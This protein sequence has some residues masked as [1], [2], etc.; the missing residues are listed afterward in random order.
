MASVRLLSFANMLLLLLI[1]IG[2]TRTRALVIRRQL[3]PPA[4]VAPAA[5]VPAA[6]QQLQTAA[7]QQTSTS[8]RSRRLKLA[9]SMPRAL[10]LIA[11]G[12]FMPTVSNGYLFCCCSL[13][14][15]QQPNR[16]H[17]ADDTEAAYSAW[18]AAGGKGVDTAFMY[19]N[20]P[21]IGRALAGATPEQRAGGRG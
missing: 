9:G 15:H 4:T 21:Q 20:Q 2:A 13:E 17:Q 3:Q 11:P 7:A 10:N 19:G 1:S 14:C 12:V 18:F 6:V 5:L 8:N 16:Q